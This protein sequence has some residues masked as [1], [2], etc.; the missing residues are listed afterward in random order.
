MYLP[1]HQFFSHESEE[2]DSSTTVVVAVPAWAA[3][4]IRVEQTAALKK[5][6]HGRLVESFIGEI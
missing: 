5:E 2:E 4:A 3:V 1:S 6:R